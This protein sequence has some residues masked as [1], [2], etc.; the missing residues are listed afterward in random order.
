MLMGLVTRSWHNNFFSQIPGCL[1]RGR[2][3][4]TQLGRSTRNLTGYDDPMIVTCSPAVRA[5]LP[6]K[7][8]AVVAWL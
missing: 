5:A 6:R 1:P 2:S 8:N 4:K 3:K 7:Y